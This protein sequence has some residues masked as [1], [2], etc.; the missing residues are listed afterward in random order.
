MTH[1]VFIAKNAHDTL[2]R[3]QLD[4]FEALWKVEAELVDEPNRARGGYSSVS[5]LTLKDANGN[6]QVFYLKR[7]SNYLI[8]NMRHP[9]GEPTVARE[10]YNIKRYAELGIPALEASFH[11]KRQVEGELQAILL[12]RNLDGYVPLDHWF[13]SW[14]T[15][16][17]CQKRDLL[18]AAAKLVALL[19]ASSIV[20]N[21]LY[22]KH[23]FLKLTEDEIE[24]RLIDLENSRA[25]LFSPWGRLRDL[26]ALYRRSQPPSRSQRL[27]FL[28]AY[29][30]KSK[31]DAQV[32]YWVARVLRRSA[33]KRAK[34]DKRM[35]QK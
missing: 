20:H 23:I 13:A 35:G 14:H 4:S 21:C 27:R 12:T 33:R 29:L 6:P 15:L 8:R 18:A 1:S 7:Q 22:P 2:R 31:V 28:L 5:R 24:A 26:E 10:F 30:G 19:H 32:R 9:L 16:G 11:A 17:Y 34:H 3:H 25:H